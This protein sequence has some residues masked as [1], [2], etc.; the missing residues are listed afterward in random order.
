MMF[1]QRVSSRR[2]SKISF[3][4]IA[5]K[6]AVIASVLIPAPASPFAL[7]TPLSSGAGASIKGD[8]L[9]AQAR[10]RK[11]AEP[12][13]AAS[14]LNILPR[15]LEP[16]A[17]PLPSPYA[18]KKT[19]R[20]KQVLIDEQGRKKTHYVS[21]RIPDA[22]KNAAR[23]RAA[24][25]RS[26]K[27]MKDS[28]LTLDTRIPLPH[29]HTTLR[30]AFEDLMIRQAPTKRLL[31]FWLQC[32]ATQGYQRSEIQP[33]NYAFLENRYNLPNRMLYS[34]NKE[35]APFRCAISAARKGGAHGPGQEHEPYI[36][37]GANP[38]DWN[39]SI[40]RAAQ[41]L[42]E[43]MRLARNNLKHALVIYNA[44]RGKAARLVRKCGGFSIAC[45]PRESRRYTAKVLNHMGVR[46]N[47]T[48]LAKNSG[49]VHLTKAHYKKLRVAHK[50]Q[51]IAML[52]G[53][54]FHA[55]NA[56]SYRRGTIGPVTRFRADISY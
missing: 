4:G 54:K 19:I 14:L 48:R 52:D 23:V 11:R 17:K 55:A 41:N 27:A 33:Q 36:A 35:E 53:R 51:R 56:S 34:V 46:D 6:F 7:T 28:G 15:I 47:F 9:D 22:A 18:A 49:K 45:A 50:R 10:Q 13:K 38:Y 29:G 8:R 5:I 37:D 2:R 3:S 32:M 1:A 44:G 31:P 16:N 40:H 39:T 20:V 12:L 26:K 24:Y 43:A 30:L 25:A 21:M 42:S